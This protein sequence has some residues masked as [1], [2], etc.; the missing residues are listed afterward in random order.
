MIS[1]GSRQSRQIRAQRDIKRKE[2]GR[3]ETERNRTNSAKAS[4]DNRRS[5]NI[6]QHRNNK[7][8]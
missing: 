6:F 3:N 8:I 4:F 7:N 2:R 1:A 5:R